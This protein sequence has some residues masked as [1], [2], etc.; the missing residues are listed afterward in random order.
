M[1]DP[2]RIEE[3]IAEALPGA[4]VRVFDTTGTNDHFEAKVIWPGFEGKSLVEQHQLVMASLKEGLKSG[5]IH[6]LSL[7]TSAKEK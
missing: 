6:A 7:K 3:I 4:K 2:K 5:A 1:F